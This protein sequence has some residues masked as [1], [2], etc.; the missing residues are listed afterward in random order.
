METSTGSR[1]PRDYRF[2]GRLVLELLVVFIGVFGASMLA[3]REARKADQEHG[4]ALR[5][6]LATELAFIHSQGRAMSF[7]T[8]DAYAD[9][10]S[11]GERPPLQPFSSRIG[12]APDVWEAALA[13]GGVRLLEPELMLELS[14]FYGS[15]RAFLAQ[16]DD[17]RADTREILLPNLDQPSSEF[18][19]DSGALRPK[20]AWY[21]EHLRW[22]SR[23]TPALAARADSLS[24]VLSR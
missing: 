23:Q 3:E 20:Y 13:S 16:L 21:L 6:A 12:F 11:S 15:M 24:K 5:R 17:H 1:K 4:R 8:I 10:I 14:N 19:D 9:A 2:A 18:Y 7:E 22:V